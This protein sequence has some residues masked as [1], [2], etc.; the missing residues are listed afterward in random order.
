[1]EDDPAVLIR[2]AA[3]RWPDG[4]FALRIDEFALARG[5]RQLLLGPSGAGK[6]TLLNLIGGFLR[7]QSGQITILGQELSNLGQTA[8]DRFRAD[9]FGV[10]FQMFNLLPYLS[11]LDNVLIPL[12]FSRH[13]RQQAGDAHACAERL[14]SRLGVAPDLHRRPAAQLSVGQQQRVAAAR[15]LIGAPQIILADEPTS[16]LDHDN[17]GKFLDLLQTE[18]Q[19]T[20]AALLMVSHDARIADHFDRVIDLTSIAR[21][22][23]RNSE[24]CCG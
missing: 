20:G 9:H 22:E 11:V 14:L 2:N 1:M 24:A 7:P 3:F 21:T 6:S 5:E 10:I 23:G 4:E 19:A 16:A 13:R 15:A 17:A 18:L 8:L 12:R